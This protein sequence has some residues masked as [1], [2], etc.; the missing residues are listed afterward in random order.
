MHVLFKYVLRNDKIS[1]PLSSWDSDCC[2]NDVLVITNGCLVNVERVLRAHWSCTEVVFVDGGMIFKHGGE[3]IHK[4]FWVK[5]KTCGGHRVWLGVFFLLC[6]SELL[7]WIVQ[8]YLQQTELCSTPDA[9]Q[10]LLY[11]SVELRTGKLMFTGAETRGVAE[12]IK[13]QLTDYCKCMH[14]TT[15]PPFAHPPLGLVSS[16]DESSNPFSCSLISSQ[17]SSVW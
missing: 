6:S 14:L 4:S 16:L 10:L 13:F 8:N 1:S 11:C 12:L 17:A 5:E 3:G 2:L 9:S 7:L 15:P